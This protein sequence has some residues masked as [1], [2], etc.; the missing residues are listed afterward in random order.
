MEVEGKETRDTKEAY[1]K[2]IYDNMNSVKGKLEE[3]KPARIKPFMQELQK[4]PS[5]SLLISNTT[6]TGSF[7]VTT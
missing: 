7:W 5:T 2:Y 1:K 3:Q 6:R 4:K